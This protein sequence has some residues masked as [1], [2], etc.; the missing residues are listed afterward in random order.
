[1]QT[2]IEASSTRGD[3]RRPVAGVVRGDMG[4]GGQGGQ[5]VALQEYRAR[6]L[7]AAIAR[8][9]RHLY[10]L[11]QLRV[12]TE[13]SAS[14]LERELME[15]ER[16]LRACRRYAGNGSSTHAEAARAECRVKGWAR[17]VRSLARMSDKPASP[18]GA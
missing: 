16:A 3:G 6:A 7:D 17:A 12:R 10:R 5:V 13:L 1:M 4:T 18:K 9:R 8:T 2:R 14:R 15:L 11:R